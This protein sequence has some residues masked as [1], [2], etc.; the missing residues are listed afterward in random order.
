VG[1]LGPKDTQ[2][3]RS[4]VYT[5]TFPCSFQKNKT[6]RSSW[7]AL[8]RSNP[9]YTTQQ[10]I[11]GSDEEII[12]EEDQELQQDGDNK[13]EPINHPVIPSEDP[14]QLED[15]QLFI[16]DGHP[17]GEI[18]ALP[19]ADDDSV[20]DFD[21][22]ITDADPSQEIIDGGEII[23]NPDDSDVCFDDRGHPGTKDWFRAIRECLKKY[24]EKAQRPTVSDSNKTKRTNLVE[25]SEQTGSH[26]GIWSIF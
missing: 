23:Y 13:T 20:S 2:N 16:I 17:I 24:Q 8:G 12:T 25:S 5:L 6:A 15:S 18:V 1:G 26:R 3:K 22:V 14:D 10:V 21:E 4:L 11:K 9:P 7:L 19:S